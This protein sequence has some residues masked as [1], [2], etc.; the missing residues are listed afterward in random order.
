MFWLPFI[1]AFVLSYVLTW[2]MKFVAINYK[3]Y[4]STTLH[5]THAKSMV[6]LGGVAIFLAFII[7]F[8]LMLELTLPRIGLLL[9]ITIIFLMGLWDDIFNLKPWLK[10]VFQLLAV[11]VAISFGIHIGQIANPFGGVIVFNQFW[12]VFLTAT[13]L[14]VVTNAMNLLDG[15]DGLAAG[16]TGIFSVVLFWLSL[17]IIVNQ[18]ETALIA[19]ILFGVV[20]GFLRWNWHPAKIFMGDSGSNMLGFL[21]AALAIIS[22]AKLATA[23]LIL[24]FPILD[25][26]WAFVRRIRQGKHPFLADK[27]HLHHRLLSV[28]VAHKNVVLI[29]LSLVA[30]LGFV[31]L[32]SGTQTK[33]ILM[34]G[35]VVFIILLIRS[36]ILVQR[37]KRP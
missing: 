14:L 6:R 29:I 8:L 30:L 1:L 19:I 22:G 33:L 17:F 2:V 34:A 32:F 10:I 23:A 36:I 7:L 3:W 4:A 27:E 5:Q 16:V 24:A 18:P 31:S 25:A 13:W 11:A 20:L 35:V 15:L 26:V 28:G 37:R 9:A 21:I 12:D